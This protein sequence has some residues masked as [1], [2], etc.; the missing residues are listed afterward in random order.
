MQYIIILT[1]A[2]HSTYCVILIYLFIIRSVRGKK[3]HAISMM[4]F[5]KPVIIN[6]GCWWMDCWNTITTLPS[7][8]WRFL[9][10]LGSRAYFYWRILGERTFHFGIIWIIAFVWHSIEFF[11]IYKIGLRLSTMGALRLPGCIVENVF[12]RLDFNKTIHRFYRSRSYQYF[13][14][15]VG[16]NGGGSADILVRNILCWKAVIKASLCNSL[17][18]CGNL[19]NCEITICARL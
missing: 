7:S 8:N 1:I 17:S 10:I 19:Y 6:V 18:N 12:P 2:N 9:L 11:D 13:S 15:G 4:N 16:I 3:L 14:D 5:K